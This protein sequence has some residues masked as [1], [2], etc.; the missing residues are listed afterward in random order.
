MRVAGFDPP[1]WHDPLLVRT[2]D[3]KEEAMKRITVALALALATGCSSGGGIR[4]EPTARFEAGDD[5][6]QF[7]ILAACGWD[8]DY[9]SVGRWI[10]V[11]PLGQVFTS[12][13]V[14]EDAAFTVGGKGGEALREALRRCPN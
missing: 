7:E 2:E 11:S 3:R 1:R 14:D 5:A 9:T 10:F 12:P 8:Y 13:R 4:H 6:L